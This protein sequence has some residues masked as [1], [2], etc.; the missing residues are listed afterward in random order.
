MSGS[1]ILFMACS[2]SAPDS[3]ADAR[4]LPSNASCENCAPGDAFFST[5]ENILTTISPSNN[6]YFQYDPFSSVPSFWVYFVYLSRCIRS[7]NRITRLF[8]KWT[9]LL[10]T[11]IRKHP[12]CFRHI[13][14]W[15]IRKCAAMLSHKNKYIIYDVLVT[16]LK[17]YWIYFIAHFNRQTIYAAK[18]QSKSKLQDIPGSLWSLVTARSTNES[19]REPSGRQSM[20]TPAACSGL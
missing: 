13:Q 18:Y 3:V 4:V 8:T 1:P 15:Q 6:Y 10:M 14:N 11:K 7:V 16:A 12:R 17:M 20:G 2:H 5:T 19:W 9:E